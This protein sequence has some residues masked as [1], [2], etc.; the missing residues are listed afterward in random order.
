MRDGEKDSDIV[1]GFRNRLE[2]WMKVTFLWT[3]SLWHWVCCRS[4]VCGKL[5]LSQIGKDYVSAKCWGGQVFSLELA[6]EEQGVVFFFFFAWYLSV[7]FVTNRIFNMRLKNTAGGAGGLFVASGIHGTTGMLFTREKSE[8]ICAEENLRWQRWQRWMVF[9]MCQPHLARTRA[10]HLPGVPWVPA[11]PAPASQGSPARAHRAH[12]PWMA[13]E[14]I[15]GCD[16]CPHGCANACGRV[17]P[18]HVAAT[19]MG[20][21]W[22]SVGMIVESYQTMM[23]VTQIVI[24]KVIDVQF[25][26]FL[27]HED[28]FGPTPVLLFSSLRSCADLYRREN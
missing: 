15:A 19:G 2:V 21:N 27:E 20:W 24:W 26:H 23:K 11:H 13:L 9:P 28:W 3:F 25:G 5:L 1:P 17:D 8:K 4:K 14:T 22:S 10:A 12:R 6:A 18:R 7:S 16:E